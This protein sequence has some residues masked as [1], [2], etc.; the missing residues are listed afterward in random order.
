[1]VENKLDDIVELL[2]SASIRNNFLIKYT[3]QLVLITIFKSERTWR[4]NTILF[5]IQ[6]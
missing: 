3:K 4:Y 5:K 6:F 2:S 1:M